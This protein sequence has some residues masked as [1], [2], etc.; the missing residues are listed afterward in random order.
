MLDSVKITEREHIMNHI[1]IVLV[2]TSHPGNIGAT[3]RAM[4][5]MDL[6]DL[7]LVNPKQF[8]HHEASSRASGADDLLAN[9][10]IHHS[11]EEALADCTLVYATSARSRTL[12]WSPKI[13][14]EA[15][16]EI[17]S[18]PNTK[19][20]IV[21]GNERTGLTNEEL[22]LAHHRVCIP[23]S[24]VYSS[25]NLAQ[26]VQVICY[27]LFKQNHHIN[28]SI[29]T[30]DSDSKTPAA[31]MDQMHS[32]ISRLEEQLQAIEFL[33]PPH[34][35]LMKRLRRLY[36]RAQLDENEI[37]ILQGILSAVNRAIDNKHNE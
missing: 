28:P 33:K 29:F 4:K 7:H 11:L 12:N 24:E 19:I 9:A 22:N 30:V 27:E 21:F 36:N 17:A 34:T 23:T 5:N 3:A 31:T 35:M 10:T 20:A 16:K 14:E 6:H 26:A 25:L 8:P 32:Y 18:Q 37:N 1:R 15:C 13:A 2:R